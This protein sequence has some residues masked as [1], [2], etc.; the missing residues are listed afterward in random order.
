MLMCWA[1]IPL[2]AAGCWGK[3]ETDE[4]GYILATGLDKGQ[5]NLVKITFQIAIPAASAGEDGGEETTET[6]S[7]ETASIFGALQLANAF[8]SKE[9]TFLH[10]ELVVVSQEIAREGLNKYINPL[11]RSR[12]IR[13]NLT[14]AVTRDSAAEYL[15]EN[16]PILE[17]NPAKQFELLF[18]AQNY[19]GIM[20]GTILNEFNKMSQSPGSNPVLALVGVKKDKK[21]E[22]EK[23][24]DFIDL[25]KSDVAYLPGE[26]P[27]EGGNKTE[28]IGLAAFRND[29]LVGFLNGS[30]TRYYQML[31]G[32]FQS[33]LMTFP[34]PEGD[35]NEV[36]VIKVKKGR[37]P[38]IK[39]DIAGDKPRLQ[40]KLILEGEYV[41]IQSG[42]EYESGQK[43]KKLEDYIESFI[44]NE[45][46]ELI[47]KSQQD[48]KSDIFGFGESTRKHFWTWQDWVDYD[49][50][51]QYLNAEINLETSMEIR[52]TGLL[53][54]TAPN[55][56][57]DA[58]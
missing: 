39:V 29:R 46:L 57:E 8:V 53:R 52:R 6:V 9:L 48:Y 11:L 26:V 24:R 16:K 31:T 7:L 41:S 2:I 5:D 54:Y 3:R 32:S 55:P 37:S 1:L 38:E 27:R 47:K 44:T 15:K 25:V 36:I 49:W 23:K 45:A 19:S 35:N 4:M 20:Q 34:D 33:A 10:N 40:V 17:K 30:E 13:R 43:Q 12:E 18:A 56:K 22:T 42:I 58:R 51:E 28:V 21:E 50:Q 14:V